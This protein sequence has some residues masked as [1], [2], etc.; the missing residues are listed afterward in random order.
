MS[1]T[2]KITRLL[3]VNDRTRKSMDGV[4]RQLKLE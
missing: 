3:E 1:S 4:H 2:L